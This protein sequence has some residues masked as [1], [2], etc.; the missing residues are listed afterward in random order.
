MNGEPF[1]VTI[2]IEAPTRS[3][4]LDLLEKMIRPR[5]EGLIKVGARTYVDLPQPDL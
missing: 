4:I 5:R 3:E 2:I 1:R